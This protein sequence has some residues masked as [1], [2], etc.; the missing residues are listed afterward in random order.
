VW[1][2]LALLPIELQS[3]TN[4]MI[5]QRIHAL[6]DFIDYLNN[7]KREYIEKYVPLCHEL[8]NLHNQRNELRPN[9]NYKDKRQNDNLQNFIK[10]KYL[11]IISNVYTPISTK[12][13]ELKIWSGDETYAS[14]WNNNYSAIS[15]FKE[16]FRSED[17]EQVM[18]YKQKYLSFRR[19]TDTDFFC[20]T[21]ALHSLDEILKELFEFFKD[22]DE[23]EF[24]RFET[25]TIKVN[26]VKEAVNGLIESN[27]KN[28]KFSIPFKTLYDAPMEPQLLT[29]S[30]NIRSEI[31]MGD[32]IRV[33]D[34][35]NNSGQI[36][37][38]KENTAKINSSD[39][40]TK[41]SFHWQKW[42]IISATILAI[43]A[44]VVAI[45][46]G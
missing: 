30:T 8:K 16:N 40:F 32:K 44:I 29:N 25:K 33:G 15:D 2:H 5:P 21:F 27:G 7:N 22:T 37:V 9:E 11:P 18:Q 24:D 26:S 1:I 45:L 6:F 17:I 36:A 20:L 39:G 4:I 14:I 43:I 13:S 34:I 42:G 46:V 12:L 41:K 10:E 23:N 28:V 19:E 31:I 35:S 3:R 38:G